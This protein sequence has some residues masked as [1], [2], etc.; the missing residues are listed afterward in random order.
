MFF[1]AIQKLNMR[2]GDMCVWKKTDYYPGEAVFVPKTAGSMEDEGVLL[3]IAFNAGTQQ[4][5]LLIIDAQCME[6]V[7]EVLLPLRLPFGLHGNFYPY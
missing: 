4:S 1:D 3:S 7:A 5:S 2:T 6:L